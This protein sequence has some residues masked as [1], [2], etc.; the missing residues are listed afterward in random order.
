ML[1]LN[2]SGSL[3]TPLRPGDARLLGVTAAKNIERLLSLCPQHRPTPL[4]R[5]EAM[6]D[7][8]GVASLF[9]KDEGQRLGL[10][11]FKAL[12]GAS[13]VIRLALSAAGKRLGRRVDPTELHESHIRRAVSGLVVGCATDGNHGRAVAAGARLTGCR[14]VIFVHEGVSDERVASIAKLGADVR[15]IAGTYDDAVFAALTVCEQRR[16]QLVSDTSWPGYEQIPLRV[17]QGYTVSVRE[18]LG[19]LPKPPTHVFVQAGVGGFAATVG[20]LLRAIYGGSAPKLVVVEPTRAA[21]L[22]ASHEAGR[23][24]KIVATHPTVM[25]MLE[26]HEPS[27][28]AWRI[29]TRTATAF[30]TVDDGDAISA[31]IALG[32]PRGGDSAIVS[33]ESGCAGFAGL[34]KALGGPCAK[35]TLGLGRRS[36]VLV[37]NT[38]GATDRARYHRLTGL[39]AVDV[40]A[41]SGVR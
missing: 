12:G 9:V 39:T 13:V 18:A 38:E 11:S 29:L 1:S 15:Q 4:V 27:Y 35:A 6:A 2:R 36:R 28:V 20:A 41:L 37:F 3:G 30:M 17:M 8:V 34:R 21:C 14:A 19:V 7:A 24:T 25:A 26:C 32:R 5:L 16:W 33:G 31:M 22:L 23:P 40:A 10:G